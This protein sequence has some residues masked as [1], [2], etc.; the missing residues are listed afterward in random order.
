[1]KTKYLLNVS[2]FIL[3]L[4]FSMS[5]LAKMDPLT[6]SSSAKPVD[7]SKLTGRV[8]TVGD[9]GYN[10]ARLSWNRYFSRYPLAIVFAKNKH[11]IVNALKFCLDN[12]I[13][14]RIR[15]GGHSLEG[16]STVDGGIVIDLSEMKRIRV[17]QKKGLAYVQPGVIQLEAVTALAKF[18]LAIPTGLEQTPGIAGVTLGGGIGLSIRE[19]GLACDHLV[20]VEVI[21]ASGEIVRATK[22]N[23]YKDLLFAC[24]GGGGGNFGVVSEFVFSA[25]PRGDVTLFKIEY[26]YEALETLVSTWQQWAPFQDARLNSALELFPEA[27][28]D[29]IGIYNGPEAELLKILEPMLAIPGSNITA[30][31]TVPYV[32]SWLFFAADV[33]GPTNDKFSSTFAYKLLPSK[34]IRI[35]KNA[36]DN[37]V[38]PRANFWFLALGGVMKDIPKTSTPFWNRD[39]LFYFEWD[40]SWADD[41]YDEDAAR[42][43]AWVE[44]LRLALKPFTKGAYVNV[45]DMDIP[46]WEQAY[47]GDN[48][49]FLKAIKKKYDPNNFFTYELQAIPPQ[50]EKMNG[51]SE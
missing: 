40:E 18:G 34:A 1:M 22:N 42:S 23:R 36:L 11:D 27:N 13:T 44:N 2:T 17:N 7:F 46:N 37:P 30:L 9:A 6:E 3:T 21:L 10:E 15:A 38:N 5:L 12:K 4:L 45:P 47:Y 8:V 33:S 32:D 35:I 24:Q 29:T 49:T 28:L 20:E 31:A 43:F 48:F 14:F 25:I 41:K 39:A 51:A 19:F 26:P 16:W 50:K